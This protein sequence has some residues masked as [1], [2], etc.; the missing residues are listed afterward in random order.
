M[1]LKKILCLLLICALLSVLLTGCGNSS[2]Q[3]PDSVIQSMLILGCEYYDPN[4]DWSWTAT[5]NIDKDAHTDRVE[6]ELTVEYEYGTVTLTNTSVFQYDR[7]SDLWNFLRL[8][9]WSEPVYTFNNN[10]RGDWKVEWFG[11][12]YGITIKSVDGGKVSLEYFV[13]EKVYGGIFTG[14]V[15]CEI[16]GKGTYEIDGEFITV[17]V[18]LP[19]GFVASWMQTSSGNSEPETKLYIQLDVVEGVGYVYVYPEISVG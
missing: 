13:A 18:E 8:G 14:D 5:H 11:S 3:V 4:A 6:V 12:T 17:P 7:S 1:K 9:V 10:L 15:Y 2:A 16:F 19:S